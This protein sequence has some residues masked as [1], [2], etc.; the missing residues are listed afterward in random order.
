VLNGA[1]DVNSDGADWT[2]DPDNAS[3]VG[4][5]IL[6]CGYRFD[7]ES[8]LYHVR[9]RMYHSTLGRW[10][11]RDPLGYVDGMGLYAYGGAGPL[12]SLDPEGLLAW[13]DVRPYAKYAPVP[14]LTVAGDTYV[15]TR[16]HEGTLAAT[17]Y[18]AAMAAGS[19]LPANRYYTVGTGF[20]PEG[21]AAAAFEGRS[22][23]QADT[24]DRVGHGLI[25]L[26]QHLGL[27]LIGC[28]LVDALF[29]T[30]GASAPTLEKPCPKEG[31]QQGPGTSASRR[32]PAENAKA[33]NQFKNNKDAAREAWE[34]R[35]GQKWPVDENGNL[36]PAEHSP[37]LKE[38]G[39]PMHVTPRDP[40]LP[41]PHN[42]PG[43]D[44]LRDYQR[45]G[46]EGTPARNANR[47]GG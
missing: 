21:A 7:P 33:R 5:E 44:G 13:K 39:D 25:G 18:A 28:K 45:W 27:S 35:T 14:G 1:D 47:N 37:P 43:A 19:I 2:T 31:G 8:G 46:A 6:F 29:G 12:R 9:H 26:G 3:D 16:P 32:T 40:G 42:I 22:E 20:S 10:L 24:L 17:G 4:N 38:G 30:A 11:G 23:T 36:W 41:D 15:V 34:Q